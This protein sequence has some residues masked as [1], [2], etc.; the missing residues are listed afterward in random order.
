[1][2]VRT[3]KRFSDLKDK[4]VREVGEEF[5]VS[6]ERYDQILSKGSLVIEVKE[7][8]AEEVADNATGGRK[9]RT[10]RK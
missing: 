5:V 8:P 6:Q 2:R 9:K 4:K 7:S 10:T 3:L 1:M